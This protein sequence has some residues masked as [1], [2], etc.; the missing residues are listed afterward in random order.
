MIIAD[1]SA[2]ACRL[3]K[4]FSIHH[5]PSVDPVTRERLYLTVISSSCLAW[6]AAFSDLGCERIPPLLLELAFVPR[7]RR[8]DCPQRSHSTLAS[9][10]AREQH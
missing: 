1:P 4:I 8:N 3:R 9:S 2:L 6:R 7:A 10:L 5:T